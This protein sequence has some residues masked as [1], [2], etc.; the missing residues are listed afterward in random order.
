MKLNVVWCDDEEFVSAFYQILLVHCLYCI[1]LI[2]FKA[3]CILYSDLLSGPWQGPRVFSARF[4]IFH[5]TSNTEH[6]TEK[7]LNR[8]PVNLGTKNSWTSKIYV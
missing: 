1:L 8:G 5:G 4:K 7:K 3:P 2:S 6:R